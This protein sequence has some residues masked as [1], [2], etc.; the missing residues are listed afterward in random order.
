MCTGETEVRRICTP[1]PHP[2]SRPSSGFL[3]SCASLSDLRFGNTAYRLLALLEE[4]VEP[5]GWRRV[6]APPPSADLGHL[7]PLRSPAPTTSVSCQAPTVS[8][9]T[10]QP[11]RPPREENTNGL[12][13]PAGGRGGGSQISPSCW[14]FPSTEGGH[15]DS[16]PKLPTGSL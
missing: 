4:A 9:E 16:S 12:C 10:T 11:P 5:G 15:P 2:H 6:L 13:L 1:H 8:P 3:G 14:V 7:I